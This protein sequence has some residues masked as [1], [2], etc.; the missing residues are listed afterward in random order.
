MAYRDDDI[1]EYILRAAWAA[2]PE[3]PESTIVATDRL[4]REQWGGTRPYVRKC[5]ADRVERPRH[6]DRRRG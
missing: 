4:L 2:A 1:I 6:D 3:I 5:R